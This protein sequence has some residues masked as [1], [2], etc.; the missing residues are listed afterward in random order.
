MKERLNKLLT[1]KS[2]VTLMVTAVFAYLA[3]VGRISGQE[4]LTIFTVIIGFYFGTQA[5]KKGG[6]T[7]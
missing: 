1:V 3:V 4:F 2:I 5:E 7:A 6:G